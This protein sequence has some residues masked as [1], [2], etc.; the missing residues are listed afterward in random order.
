M[1]ANPRTE[2]FFSGIGFEGSRKTQGELLWSERI[3]ETG[4]GDGEG[5]GRARD[6][7]TVTT[8]PLPRRRRG[9]PAKVVGRAEPLQPRR[10]WRLR[11]QRG[12]LAVLGY[13]VQEDEDQERYDGAF[14]VRAVTR[15]RIC[16]AMPGGTGYNIRSFRGPSRTKPG[17]GITTRNCGDHRREGIGIKRVAVAPAS[18]DPWLSGIVSGYN[19]GTMSK[20]ERGRLA[21]PWCDKGCVLMPLPSP[22]SP[23]CSTRRTCC[24]SFLREG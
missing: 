5:P 14:G 11:P 13:G 22:E 16:S 12:A 3:D 20:E 10:P 17:A 7:R 1:P 4:D 2:S 9:V 19:P 24:S 18:S 8:T 6:R 21:S 23:G 15:L